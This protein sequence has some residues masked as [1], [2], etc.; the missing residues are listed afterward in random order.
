MK[1]KQ[2]ETQKLRKEGTGRWLLDGEKF[3]EWQDNAGSLWI[4]GPSGAGKSVLSS[5]VINNQLFDD[6]RLFKDQADAPPAPAVTFFYF[7]FWS[8][9]GESVENVLRRMVLQLSAQSPYLYRALDKLYTL[10][11]GHTLPTYSDLLQVF[12]QLFQELGRTYIVLDA[13]DECNKSDLEKLLALVLM[14]WTWTRT[15]VHLLMTSQLCCIFAESFADVP[16]VTLELNAVQDDIVF[17]I[18]NGLQTKFSLG[19]WWP[20]ADLITT[21]VA[22]KSKGMF[23]LAACL[24]IKLSHCNWEDEL[25]KTLGNLLDDLFGIYNR[26]L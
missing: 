12:A 5:A 19:I 23:H 22:Q 15:P 26:F 24:L 21:R 25:D 7:D 13:L 14:L 18:T 3:I 17:F 4:V 1:Q 16:S 9:Q 11:N 10:S 8:Q 6:R 2:A 20:K